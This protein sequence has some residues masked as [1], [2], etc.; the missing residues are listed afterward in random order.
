MHGPYGRR[1]HH[2]DAKAN[3]EPHCNA[4]PTTAGSRGRRWQRVRIWFLAV[5][6]R[7]RVSGT[8][9]SS[10]PEEAVGAS[11]RILALWLAHGARARGAKRR[12]AA[13]ACALTYGRHVELVLRIRRIREARL[14]HAASVEARGVLPGCAMRVAWYPAHADVIREGV[15]VERAADDG[16]IRDWVVARHGGRHIGIRAPV[17]VHV[18]HRPKGDVYWRARWSVGGLQRAARPLR[19]RVPVECWGDQAAL[20]LE[21]CQLRIPLL[22]APRKARGPS[23]DVVAAVREAVFGCRPMGGVKGGNSRRTGASDAEIRGHNLGARR[24]VVC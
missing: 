1:N 4:T 21:V 3:G 11:A 9:A 12:V 8:I 7:K 2:D 24:C 17:I 23:D 18:T 10:G 15:I 22:D 19:A 6:H 20:T 5:A 13:R 14:L 16:H